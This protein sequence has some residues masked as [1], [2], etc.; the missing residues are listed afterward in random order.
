MSELL[1]AIIETYCD[2]EIVPIAGLDD[3]VIGIDPYTSRLIYSVNKCIEI[4]MKDSNDYDIAKEHFFSNI[5]DA[6]IGEK[7]PIFC[8]DDF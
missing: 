8:D 3:A 1:D 7:T 4:L 2:T 5:Y 6:H